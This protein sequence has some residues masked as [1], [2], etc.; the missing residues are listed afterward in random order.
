MIGAVQV[1]ESGR[2]DLG[3]VRGCVGDGDRLRDGEGGVPAD[4]CLAIGSFDPAADFLDPFRKGVGF[5]S[6]RCGDPFL[7]R[8]AL[9]GAVADRITGQ[10]VDEL[11][12]E[13]VHVLGVDLPGQAQLGGAGAEPSS[14]RLAVGDG[15]QVVALGLLGHASAAGVV[16]GGGGLSDADDHA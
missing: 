1:A 11:A 5:G 4:H 8:H 13:L 10:R 3:A 6:D 2:G 15:V 14:G 9:G 7:R 16:L 12:V